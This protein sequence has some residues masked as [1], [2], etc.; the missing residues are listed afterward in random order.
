[1]PMPKYLRNLDGTAGKPR[2]SEGTMLSE[3]PVNDCTLRDVASFL[4]QSD[5]HAALTLMSGPQAST[6]T[7]S[8]GAPR[9]RTVA[10]SHT[11]P[12][13]P[14]LCSR[15]HN[16][17]RLHLNATKKPIVWAMTLPAT[18]VYRMGNSVLMSRDLVTTD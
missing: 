13:V 11:R 7:V 2:L 14:Q 18:S 10:V 1:M 8:A 5:A 3:G 17:D 12:Q 4:V 6:L 9:A 16:L 15:S